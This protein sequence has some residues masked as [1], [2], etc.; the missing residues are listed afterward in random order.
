M[1]TDTKNGTMNS[2]TGNALSQTVHTSQTAENDWSRLE[3]QKRRHSLNRVA[4][5]TG[6]L[7]VMAMLAAVGLWPISS[8]IGISLGI[9]EIAAL[10]LRQH[11]LDKMSGRWM[12]LDQT[13]YGERWGSIFTTLKRL[14]ADTPATAKDRAYRLWK[15]ASGYSA[16]LARLFPFVLIVTLG[17]KIENQIALLIMLVAIYPFLEIARYHDALNQIRKLRNQ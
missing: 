4:A 13:L 1:K 16:G 12:N 6:I 10:G 9:V 15:K 7:V 5:R 17:D 2:E 8:A 3:S 11:P 14:Q